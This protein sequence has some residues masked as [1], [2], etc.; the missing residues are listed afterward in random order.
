MTLSPTLPALARARAQFPA[1]AR[2]SQGVT[3]VFFDN[4]GGTQVPQSVIDAMT[5]YLVHTNANTHGAF[6]TSRLSDALLDEAHRAAADLVGAASPSEVVFGHNMTTLTFHISRSLAHEIQPGDEIVVTHLDHDG[7]I[8]PWLLMARDRGATVRWVDIHADDCTL[9]LDTL[10]AALSPRTRIVAFGYASNAVGT[11]HPV[12]QMVDMAHSVGALAYIDAVQSV[13]HLPTDVQASGA[14]FLVCSAYKFFGPHAGILYGRRELLDRLP[15]Y[16][17]RVADDVP[18]GKF[19]TGTQN[20][21]AQAGTLAAIEYLASLADD[22]ESGVKSTELEGTRLKLT[23]NRRARLVKSM[24]LVAE[25][26]RGLVGRLLGGLT[27]IPGLRVWGIT[28]P[29]RL[30]ER[31]PTVAFT[32]PGLTPEAIAEALGEREIYTWWGNFAAPAVTLRLG[33]EPTGV[34]RVGLAHYN[35]VEEVDRLLNALD[36]IVKSSE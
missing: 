20:H 10:A 9:D 21:E 7:N 34:L 3:P 13:P 14:D 8:M 1:L 4:P 33:L 26:E 18:P 22:D 12:R 35:T 11:V 30:H 31:V 6:R 23:G 19:E 25:Y 5:D 32:L 24:S 29:A 28:D 36:E 15:A 17:I 2:R 27:A 16:K